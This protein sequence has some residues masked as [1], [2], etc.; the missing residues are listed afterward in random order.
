MKTLTVSVRDEDFGKLKNDLEKLSYVE[1]FAPAEKEIDL[2]SL[3]SQD[4]LAQDWLS[5]EDSRYD[6]LSIK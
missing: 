6:E 1:I 3:V 2:V 4:S 5:E